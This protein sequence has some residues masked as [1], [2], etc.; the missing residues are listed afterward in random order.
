MALQETEE[1]NKIRSSGKLTIYGWL[2]FVTGII[3]F[4]YGVSAKNSNFLGIALFLLFL[5]LFSYIISHINFSNIKVTVWTTDKIFATI[6]IPVEISF[7]NSNR[8]FEVHSLKFES[9]I[10]GNGSYYNQDVSSAVIPQNHDVVSVGTI[11]ASS[12]I[13]ITENT[14]IRKRGCYASFEYRISSN[15]PFGLIEWCYEGTKLLQLVVYPRPRSVK[16]LRSDFSAGIGAEDSAIEIV[17]DGS[18][19]IKGVKEFSNGMPLKLIHWP[20][21]AHF[22]YPVVKDLEASS[23]EEFVIIFHSWEPRGEFNAKST[24]HALEFLT[25]LFLYFYDHNIEFDFFA[26]FNDWKLIR[27]DSSEDT[28]ERALLSL[29]YATITTVHDFNPV[30]DIIDALPENDQ[31]TLIVSNTPKKHWSHLLK[32]NNMTICLDTL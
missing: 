25:G 14:I 8:I 10:L 2:F 17:Q 30:Y 3:I 18:G 5:L 28:L 20:L 24:K 4:I 1:K 13:S 21:S 9:A 12:I 23:S 26:S 31:K 32:N 6:P 15:F 11:P 7:T 16:E 29:V 27:V 22:Q 19:D